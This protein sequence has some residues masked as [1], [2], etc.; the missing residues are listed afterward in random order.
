MK[1]IPTPLR[2][3]ANLSIGLY[4][5]DDIPTGIQRSLAFQWASKSPEELDRLARQMNSHTM[6]REKQDE[7][8]PLYAVFV[9]DT[10]WATLGYRQQ[11]PVEEVLASFAYAMKAADRADGTPLFTRRTGE[12]EYRKVIGAAD[13]AGLSKE[14]YKAASDEWSRRLRVLQKAAREKERL[15]VLVDI[16]DID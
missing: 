6:V 13:L 10:S 2:Y 1:Q 3:F 8:F 11:K 5:H 9:A 12:R 4:K 14:E 15:R 16:Q 7:L